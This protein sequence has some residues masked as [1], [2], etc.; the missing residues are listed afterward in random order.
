M[1]QLRRLDQA[2]ELFLNIYNLYVLNLN[3]NRKMLFSYEKYK[4]IMA[5]MIL[6]TQ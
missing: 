1:M 6:Q 4:K 3:I 5:Y 2:R